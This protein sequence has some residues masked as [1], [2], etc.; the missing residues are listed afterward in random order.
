MINIEELEV[1]VALVELFTT[2]FLYA[3]QNVYGF[4]VALI[5]VLFT[6]TG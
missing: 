4:F 2:L 3:F 5:G 1:L 6:L